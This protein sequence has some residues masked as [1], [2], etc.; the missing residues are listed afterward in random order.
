MLFFDLDHFNCFFR[1]IMKETWK[2][3]SGF[4]KQR[5]R[6]SKNQQRPCEDQ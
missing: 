5:I 6:Y 4:P 3:E 1:N 2:R